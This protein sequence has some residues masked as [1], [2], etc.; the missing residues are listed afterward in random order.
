MQPSDSPICIDERFLID[1]LNRGL[2]RAERQFHLRSTERFRC[3]EP[4]A[5]V[6][7][8]SWKEYIRDYYDPSSLNL[9][10]DFAAIVKRWIKQNKNILDL[11]FGEAALSPHPNRVNKPQPHFGEAVLATLIRYELI[12]RNCRALRELNVGCFLGGSMSYGKFFNVRQTVGTADRGVESDIDL[13]L[14]ADFN[15]VRKRLE[16]PSVIDQYAEISKV[17]ELNRARNIATTPH[18]ALALLYGLR[19]LFLAGDAAV[20]EEN[21]QNRNLVLSKKFNINLGFEVGRLFYPEVDRFYFPLSVHVCSQEAFETLTQPIAFDEYESG[22][23]VTPKITDIRVDSKVSDQLVYSTMDAIAVPESASKF[24]KDQKTVDFGNSK[25]ERF[26]CEIPAYLYWEGRFVSGMYQNLILPAFEII[27]DT[28]DG[29][30]HH[31]VNSLKTFLKNESLRERREFLDSAISISNLHPRHPIFLT[32]ITEECNRITEKRTTQDPASI[33]ESYKEIR[34][35]SSRRIFHSKYGSEINLESEVVREIRTRFGES[36]KT[37]NIL[38][39]GC[40][41]GRFLERLYDAGYR[42]RLV[43]IDVVPHRY[44]PKT[45]GGIA[46]LY[47]KDISEL[48]EHLGNPEENEFDVILALHVLYHIADVSAVLEQSIKYLRKGG[49]FIA[50]TNS[51]QSLPFLSSVFREAL[52]SNGVGNFSE[53]RYRTFSSENAQHC[54]REFFSIVKNSIFEIDIEITDKKD[55]LNYLESSFENYDVENS[56]ELR[57]G[58]LT[59]IESHLDNNVERTFPDRKIVSI[60][61]GSNAI[62]I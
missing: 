59:W 48:E 15:A 27:S 57:E 42:G 56:P 32:S 29:K 6:L 60:A 2:R 3:K 26:I 12:I 4:L 40:D 33:V 34:N 17:A 7:I 19:P 1:S 18:H 25:A 20:R 45:D 21:L 22:G 16:E 58:I 55:I 46:L 5:E 10:L 41:T 13:L 14:V 39:L 61:I 31:G 9:L 28:N 37:K 62:E 8:N 36:A 30:L 47:G 43:G 50:S 52:L 51:N 35:L 23:K 49:I 54:L 44:E 38:E 53:E 24:G 11:N